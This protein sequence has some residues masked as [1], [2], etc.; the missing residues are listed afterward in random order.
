MKQTIHEKAAKGFQTAG[1]AYERG[2]PEYPKEAIECLVE[3]LGITRQSIVVDLGAGTGKFTKLLIP[4][5][6]KIIAVE[7]VEGMIRKFKALYPE[8]EVMVGTAESIPLPDQSVDAIIAA[9]AAHWFKGELSLKEIHR[10]LKPNG[11]LGLIWNARDESLEWVAEMTRIIDPHEGGAPRYK[12][13][14]WR[15]PFESTN[16]FS[17][18]QY[19]N[20]RYVQSGPRQMVLDRVAS[21][22]FISALPESDHK[23]VLAQINQLLE[24]NPVT[25]AKEAIDLPYRTDVF[26]CSRK[27]L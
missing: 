13:M 18:L 11:K 9:Q 22:S 19:K 5:G 16:L 2:R 20:F 17:P 25:R 24:A 3:A 6:P 4:Y 8:T 27:D 21:I 26:W 1:D 12:S 14:N 23:S 10:V 15:K 7:P